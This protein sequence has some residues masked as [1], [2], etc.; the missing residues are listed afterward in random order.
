VPHRAS[1]LAVLTTASVMVTASI[2]GTSAPAMAD[3]SPPPVTGNDVYTVD[4]RGPEFG[5]VTLL[6]VL[7]NDSAPSG[8]AL[9]ICRVQAPERGLSVAEVSPD[10]D[11][12]IETPNSGLG[13]SNSGG[14]AEDAHEQLAVLSW[15][16]QPGTYQFSYG[17]GDTEH[18]TP[19]TVTVTVTETPEVTVRKVDRPG[20]LRFTNPRDRGVVVIYGG[21]D[22][23]RPDGRVRLAPGAHAT[24]RVERRA[25]RW[26]A[27]FRRTGEIIGDGVVRGIRLPGSA[28]GNGKADGGTQPRLTAAML[29]AWRS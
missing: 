14:S 6:D 2:L 24:E 20:R 16:N 11:F 8:A 12:S 3:D 26:I 7:A 22:Q 18:L 10:G 17:A 13:V 4:A 1:R 5:G 25:I 29:R 27:L 23:R 21:L 19:A 28:S 15:A 9:E